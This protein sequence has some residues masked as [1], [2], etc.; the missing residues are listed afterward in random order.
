MSGLIGQ[1]EG[2]AAPA[3]RRRGL[4]RLREGVR[5]SPWFVKIAAKLVLKRLPA[6]YR[7]WKRLGLF[8][9]GPGDDP[10]YGEAVFARHFALARPA[11]GFTCL[12]M[13][14]G[15]AL[16]TAVLARAHGAAATWLVDVGDFAGR[17]MAPYRLLAGRLTAAGLPS[18]PDDALA[19]RTTLLAWSNAR[20]LTGGLASLREVPDA[21]VDFLFSQAV[22]EHVRLAEFAATLAETRRVMRPGG[23]CSHRID[24]RDHLGGALNNLRFPRGVWESRLFAESGFYTNRLRRGDLLA[25]FADAGFAAEVVGE[26]RWPRLPTPRRALARPFRDMPDA[27]LLVSALDIVLRPLPA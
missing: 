10:A 23:V 8:E 16:T 22:L 25:L 26:E 12:E 24:L 4:L 18:P 14:P 1:H 2:E 9:H 20:Y 21:S 5:R 15:D 3:K 6:P 17:A 7:L 13:G 11:A 27:E 19:D